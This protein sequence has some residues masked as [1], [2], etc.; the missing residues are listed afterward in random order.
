MEKISIIVPVYQVEK[1]IAQCIQSIQDQTFTNFELILI[2]DGSKDRSGEI[3]DYYANDDKRIKVIH[4]KNSGAAAARNKG[5]DIASGEYI[6]FVDGDDYIDPNMLQR[7]YDQIKESSYDLVVCNFLNLHTDSKK[8]FH[9]SM[10][11]EIVTGR[12]V[13]A[14][15][16]N[17]KNF[18]VWTIVWNKIYKKEIFNHLRFLP[19]RYFEDEFFSDQLYLKCGQ[20]CVIPDILCYHR[21]LETSTMNTQKIR[22]YL[23]LLEALKI[24]IKIYEEQK[25]PIDEIYKLLIYLLEPYTNCRK[26]NFQGQDKKRYQDIRKF[27]RRTAKKLQKSELSLLK[28]SSL[29]MI[30]VFPT[31]TY[32]MA[33]KFRDRLEKYL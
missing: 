30:S 28:K 9:L 8:D 29:I 25:L 26:A 5:L 18:G 15:R 7:L 17:Q 2:N 23:D 4:T 1:Y 27:I 3:C 22:N 32:R 21:V 14:H 16:K 11:E 12:E 24:R 33:M 6:V 31:T 13:L 20:I 10:K 19:G